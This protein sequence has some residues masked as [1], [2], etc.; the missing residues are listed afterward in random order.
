[1]LGGP[2][3]NVRV[4]AFPVFHHRREQKQITAPF[5]FLLQAAADLVARLRFH[6][7]PASGTALSPEPREEQPKEVVNLCDGRD[8][9]LAPAARVAL[10]D[11]DRRRNARD[12]VHVR[13][14]HLFHKLARVGVHRI[15][16]TPLALGKNQVKCQRAFARAAHAGDDDELAARNDGG[17]VLQI[18]LARAMDA[19]GVG[20]GWFG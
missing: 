17:E 19:D 9:A 14:R 10:L 1:M 13:A 16:E 2:L 12:E 6:R 5:Q 18:V 8:G 7:N 3:G 15:E 4:K 11:A 20:G